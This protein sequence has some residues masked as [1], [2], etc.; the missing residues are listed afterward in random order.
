MIKKIT[1]QYVGLGNNFLQPQDKQFLNSLGQWQQRAE[2]AYH[3]FITDP[4][5]LMEF[6][7]LAE[8]A[9]TPLTSH[10]TDRKPR[11]TGKLLLQGLMASDECGDSGMG[12]GY[13][14]WEF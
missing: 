5:V 10:C 9:Q 12:L 3:H 6:F 11:T 7:F 13:Y 4:I 1:C 14:F 2:T 8:S